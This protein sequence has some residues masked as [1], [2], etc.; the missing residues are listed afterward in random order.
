MMKE[1]TLTGRTYEW[2]CRN[3]FRQWTFKG[4]DEYFEHTP[5][6]LD[7]KYSNFPS[8]RTYLDKITSLGLGDQVVTLEN[9]KPLI[10]RLGEWWDKVDE[11]WSNYTDDEKNGH[12]MNSIRF[13]V[14]NIL[15]DPTVDPEILRYSFLHNPKGV[16]DVVKSSVCPD[17]LLVQI[18]KGSGKKGDTTTKTKGGDITCFVLMNP[19]VSGEIVDLCSKNTKR[20]N[21]L[22][23]VIFH[24]NVRKDTLVRIYHDP[25]VKSDKLKMSV[26]EVMVKKG[27]LKV[28]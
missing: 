23:G 26:L 22:E 5:I 4:I 25:K 16:I 28:E 19:T 15:K 2:Y 8:H 7:Q 13:V 3:E 27:F 20:I 14:G 6:D 18:I 17:D 12:E 11:S 9:I 24:R 10:K 21:N 1:E